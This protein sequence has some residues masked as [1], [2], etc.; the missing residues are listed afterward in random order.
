M[1]S[2]RSSAKDKKRPYLSYL[3]RLWLAKDDGA[4]WR[5]SLEAPNGAERH[6]FT[7]LEELY[8]FLE[9]QTRDLAAAE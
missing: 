7:N 1:A 3:L 2:E 8:A 6:G 5:A 4:V 9:A